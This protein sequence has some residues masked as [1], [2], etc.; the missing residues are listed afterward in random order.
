ME[1]RM[2]N[3]FKGTTEYS[4]HMNTQELLAYIELQIV[5]NNKKAKTE[6]EEAMKYLAEENY[7][8]DEYEP[9]GDDYYYSSD[10]DR[11]IHEDYKKD[12]DEAWEE[13]DTVEDCKQ[14]LSP[15]EEFKKFQGCGSW[16]GEEMFES[17]EED[18]LPEE[19]YCH[20]DLT[21]FTESEWS[22]RN[23]SMKDADEMKKVILITN[24]EEARSEIVSPEEKKTQ[25]DEGVAILG[26]DE[27]EE[28]GR[29]DGFCQVEPVIRD[30][31][32]R[33]SGGA[34]D[35][36][37]KIRQS[38]NKSTTILELLQFAE[39]VLVSDYHNISSCSSCA[40]SSCSKCK[41]CLLYTSPSPRDS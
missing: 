6:A 26:E 35:L 24:E 34:R 40:K 1:G 29:I 13:V 9:E 39:D 21:M 31:A 8:K 15:E 36:R 19:K 30:D 7:F 17:E 23:N 20:E 41:S 4:K 14:E 38:E 28:E 16:I 22:Q 2:L 11:D 27:A 33:A 10:D 5:A 25:E 18:L 32:V 12:G 3:R 37:N